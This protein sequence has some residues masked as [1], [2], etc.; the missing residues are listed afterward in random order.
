M[1]T[2]TTGMFD[3]CGLRCSVLAL[4]LSASCLF[5]EPAAD[6]SAERAEESIS[7]CISEQNANE[8]CDLL[9]DESVSEKEIPWLD[10]SHAAISYSVKAISDRFDRF[11]DATA[12]EEAGD[13][14]VKVALAAESREGR[15]VRFKTKAD[16]RLDLPRLERRW[17]L[18]LQNVD[19]REDPLI[20]QKSDEGYY[21]GLRLLLRKTPLTRVHV[22]G[23]L[24]NSGGP[25]LFGRMRWRWQYAWDPHMVRATQFVYWYDRKGFGE[26][27][28]LEYEYA[29][30]PDW[31]FQMRGD[32]DWGE[33]TQGVEWTQSIA[34]ARMLRYRHGWVFFCGADGATLPVAVV[35]RYRA[36]IRRRTR[37]YRD[38][39]FLDVEPGVEFRREKD[40]KSEAL[41]RIRIE[42]LFGPGSQ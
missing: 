23:G 12:D 7:D 8:A 17:N 34:L 20:D 37:L 35:D 22:D 24:R 40:F 5:A 41:F 18:F 6:S 19:L 3:L 21:A 13:T 4:I 33:V 31:L 11:F 27:T 25:V 1:T 28:R 9:P 15:G 14:R 26:T 29:V 2:L 16:V 39:L 38:W 30:S 32:A 42:M 10:R 36:G